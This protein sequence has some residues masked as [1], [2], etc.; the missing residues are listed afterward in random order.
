MKLKIGQSGTLLNDMSF[1]FKIMV[2]KLFLEIGFWYYG[3]FVDMGVG[4]GNT[5]LDVRVTHLIGSGRRWNN[6]ARKLAAVT[7]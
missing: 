5:M 4:K 3:Q 2:N 1:R 7:H 6:W